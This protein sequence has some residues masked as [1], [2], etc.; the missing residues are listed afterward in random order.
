MQATDGA[1]ARHEVPVRR[2]AYSFV[3]ALV[4]LVL[5]LF[6]TAA[7]YMMLDPFYMG[8]LSYL[9]GGDVGSAVTVDAPSWPVRMVAVAA[10]ALGV[11]AFRRWQEEARREPERYA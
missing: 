8:I 6:F 3:V 2:R 4:V 10:L 11:L 7:Y 9:I 5:A 1:G